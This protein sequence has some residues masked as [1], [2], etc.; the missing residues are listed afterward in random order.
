MTP[1][2]DSPVLVG[3]DPTVQKFDKLMGFLKSGQARTFT[4]AELETQINAY[5]RDLLRQAMQDHL[6]VR[7]Y[8]EPR[9][10][11][12]VDADEVPHTT[13]ERNQTRTLTTIFGDVKVG[14][15]A[16]RH[17]GTTNLYPGGCLP[18]SPGRTILTRVAPIGRDR[19][20]AGFL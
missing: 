20:G 12:V 11:D 4:H 16:Y 18:K 9:R 7:A 10:T 5:G 13:V 2:T 1:T 19:S 3:Y 6:T 8:E 17:P 15:L 14:R